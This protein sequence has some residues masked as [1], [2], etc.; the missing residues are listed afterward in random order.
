MFTNIVIGVI[1][2]V[3]ILSIFCA[4][5]CKVLNKIFRDKYDKIYEDELNKRRGDLSSF[6][7]NTAF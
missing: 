7:D 3:L 6:D 5:R 2:T 1:I 4:I